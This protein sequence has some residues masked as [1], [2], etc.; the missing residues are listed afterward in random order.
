MNISLDKLKYF[1]EVARLEHV[2]L[3]SKSLGISASAISTAISS[4]EAELGCELFERSLQRIH[5][6]ERGMLLREE[7]APILMQLES[8]GEKVSGKETTLKGHI[9]VGGSYFLAQQYLWPV[10][11]KLQKENAETTIEISPLRSTQV[12]QEVIS[13]ALD[14]GITISPSGNPL[15]EK[16]VLYKGNLCIVVSKKHPMVKLIKAKSF[17]FKLLNDYPAA[18]HKYSP[19]IDYRETHAFGRLGVEPIIKNFYHSEEL[20]IKSVLNSEMWAVVPDV[21]YEH[22][23]SDLFLV[24]LPKE[25]NASYEICSI[26]RKAMKN[27]TVYPILDELLRM[28]INSRRTLTPRFI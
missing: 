13:G 1:L 12:T 23:K 17:K 7:L 18:I 20:A 10:L 5:L 6:N 3:A 16:N 19:G 2:G 22:F 11:H 8:L 28:I 14:Y 21:V 26:Y 24:P 9:N 27:R 4:L 25:W 15:L